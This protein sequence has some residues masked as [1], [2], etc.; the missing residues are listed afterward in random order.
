MTNP[1]N[2]QEANKADL[3]FILGLLVIIIVMIS[4]NFIFGSIIAMSYCIIFII[5]GNLHNIEYKVT[6]SEIKKGEMMISH[7]QE[8]AR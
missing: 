3:L 6:S 8:N 1:I 2:K 5:Y 4:N 7:V